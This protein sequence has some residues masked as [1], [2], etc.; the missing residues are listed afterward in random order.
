MSEGIFSHPPLDTLVMFSLEVLNV[1]FHP[2]SHHLPL[3][4]KVGVGNLQGWGH[5]LGWN[6]GLGPACLRSSGLPPVHEGMAEGV[7]DQSRHAHRYG[8]G[9]GGPLLWVG[10]PYP[11]HSLN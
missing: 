3:Q 9:A 11:A 6:A 8:G 5:I 1:E 4:P 2:R 7:R 10:P